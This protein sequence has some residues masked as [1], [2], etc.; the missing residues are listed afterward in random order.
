ML[1]ENLLQVEEECRS[2]HLQGFLLYRMLLVLP[3]PAFISEHHKALGHIFDRA[4]ITG[5]HIS[6][7]AN[8]IDGWAQSW[9][10]K[11]EKARLQAL[12]RGYYD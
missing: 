7:P 9:I 1:R 10:F 2:G 3:F 12:P 8:I 4:K 6:R 11:I 5:Q